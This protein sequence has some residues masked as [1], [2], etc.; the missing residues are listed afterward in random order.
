MLFRSGV[1]LLE[2]AFTKKGNQIPTANGTAGG[3]EFA[4]LNLSFGDNIQVALP[5][6]LNF[7]AAGNLTLN[8]KWGDLHPQGIVRLNGGYVNLF[9]SLLRLSGEENQVEFFPERGLNPYLNVQLA[10]STTETT[11]SRLPADPLSS[12]VRDP[13]TEIGRAHV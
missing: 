13:F 2:K 9:A 7:A 5:P 1:V 12:E 10:A 8:G 6:I 4:G 11:P 3:V